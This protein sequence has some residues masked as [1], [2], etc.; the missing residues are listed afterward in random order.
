MD[1]QYFKK[2]AEVV[3]ND[4]DKKLIRSGHSLE[5]LED[6][7]NKHQITVEKAKGRMRE[8]YKLACETEEKLADYS[9]N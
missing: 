1:N 7:I 9:T 2:E 6:G 5:E 3:L 4:Y 8:L